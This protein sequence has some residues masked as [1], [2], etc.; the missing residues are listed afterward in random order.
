MTTPFDEGGRIVESAFV[1]NLERYG[2]TGLTGVL[3]AGTTGEGVHLDASE[4]CR[5]LECAAQAAGHLQILAGLPGQSVVQSVRELREWEKLPV[6]AVL[7]A[8]PNYY[9]PRM[10][11]NAVET[12]YRALADESP[13]PVL[14]YNIPR[15]SGIEMGARL[16]TRLARHPRIAGIKESSGNLGLVQRLLEDTSGDDFVVLSGSAETFG[17]AVDLGVRGGILAAA[18]VVPDLAVAV[19]HSAG[20]PEG[21]ADLRRRLFE[22]ASAVVSEGGVAGI[23]AAMDETGFEGLC[24]RLPLGP[25]RPEERERIRHVLAAQSRVLRP[26]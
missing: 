17:A 16:V 24:T 20:D 4:R 13:F 11:E 1:R 15:L 8:V 12:Y 21:S 7:A 19:L 18:C 2:K 9:R 14:L 25:L 23:K 3:V 5:L 10:T 6:R 22:V 26:A